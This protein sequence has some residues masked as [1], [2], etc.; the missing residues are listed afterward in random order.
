MK[1]VLDDKAVPDSVKQKIQFIE[2]VKRFA[3]DSIGLKPSEN[4]TTFYDQDNKPLLWVLTV[5]EPFKLKAYEWKFPLLGSVSYKGFFDYDNAKEE[6]LSMKSQGYDTDLGEVSAWSTLG[7]FHDPILSNM[8]YRSKG[9]IAEL[10]I[11]E[12]THSTIYLKSN[13]N[14]NENLASVCGEQGAIR[15]LKSVYGEKSDELTD[16]LNRKEDY[17]RFSRQMLIGTHLLDS[18][19]TIMNDSLVIRKDAFKGKVDK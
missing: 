17:D 11:H 14:L 2:T 15:F 4:Y 5:S 9:Q 16:Y 19:Y 6:E 18:L 1:E 10:I 7:W 8:I 13:V 3:I 12:L